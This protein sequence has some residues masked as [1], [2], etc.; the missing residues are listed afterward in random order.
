MI[1][2]RALL[3]SA[4]AAAAAFAVATSV[5]AQN[6]PSGPPI[7]IGLIAEQTGALLRINGNVPNDDLITNLPHG[8]CVE[9]PC[10]VDRGEF[11]LAWWGPSP[12]SWPP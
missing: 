11:T 10:L 7:K 8:V 1:N 5:P 9:V 12:H 2:T 3:A 6:A 4:L